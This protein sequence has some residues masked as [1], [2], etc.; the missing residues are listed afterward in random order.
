MYIGARKTPAL[1]VVAGFGRLVILIPN[2]IVHWL[3]LP[4]EI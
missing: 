1:S 2:R 4:L 3:I